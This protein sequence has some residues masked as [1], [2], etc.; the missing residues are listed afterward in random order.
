MNGNG[1]DAD[2]KWDGLEGTDMHCIALLALNRSCTYISV[3][4]D[5]NSRVRRTIEYTLVLMM[6]RCCQRR[7]LSPTGID[8][9]LACKEIVQTRM[10]DRPGRSYRTLPLDGFRLSS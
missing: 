8:A 9:L 5:T 2:M 4:Y 3:L 10:H 6:C 7:E 1:V